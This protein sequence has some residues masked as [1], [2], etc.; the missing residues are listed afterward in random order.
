MT[1][2]TNP[3]IVHREGKFTNPSLAA[4]AAWLPTK[5]ADYRI[6]YDPTAI[7][8][9]TGLTF[10]NLRLPDSKAPTAGYP[11]AVIIH[12]GAWTPDWGYDYTEPFA[13]QV[14]GRGVF[15]LSG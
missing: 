1:A 8:S 13:G 4:I 3:V 9:S 14:P 11:V 7:D 2:G 10:G 5:P 15:D 12:G 6:A